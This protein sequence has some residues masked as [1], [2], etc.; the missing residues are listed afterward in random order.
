VPDPISV[1]LIGRDSTGKVVCQETVH[2][3][4]SAAQIT[5]RWLEAGLTVE[6]NAGDVFFSIVKTVEKLTPNLRLQTLPE[7][8]K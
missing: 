6:R 4:N 5:T 3:S 2:D 7:P 1:T 8:H